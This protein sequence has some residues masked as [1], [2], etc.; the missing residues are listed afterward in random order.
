MWTERLA[1]SRIGV[2][3]S[4]VVSLLWLSSVYPNP[5]KEQNK[6]E[7]KRTGRNKKKQKQER[8]RK[9][10]FQSLLKPATRSVRN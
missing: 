9:I 2:F 7:Q 1:K 5:V 10:L 3:S 8:T 6:N 4:V